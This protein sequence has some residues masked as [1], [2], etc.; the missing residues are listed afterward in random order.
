MLT[1]AGVCALNVRAESQSRSAALN[2]QHIPDVRKGEA[3]EGEVSPLVAR[4]DEGADEAGDDHDE[5]H[6]DDGDDVR[7]RKARVEEQL[8][9]EER[10]RDRPV[11]VANVLRGA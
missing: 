6:E 4:G 2:G 10:S 11:D 3:A 7:E 1:G 9:E 5:V 8:E